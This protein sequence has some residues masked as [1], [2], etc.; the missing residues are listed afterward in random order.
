MTGVAVGHGRLSVT[1]KIIPPSAGGIEDTRSRVQAATE[2]LFAYFNH[3]VCGI[4]VNFARL[5]SVGCA[6]MM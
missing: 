4:I 1:V 5:T 3:C 2:G 6:E